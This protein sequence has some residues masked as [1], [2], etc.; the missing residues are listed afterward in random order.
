MKTVE[1]IKELARTRLEEAEILCNNGKYDGAFYL[2]GYSVELMLKAK[3]CQHLDI[4]DLF[5]EDAG[6]EISEK[7]KVKAAVKTVRDSV[8]SHDL[9][10]LFIYSGLA[11]KFQQAKA[12][13]WELMETYG[14]LISLVQAKE[15]KLWSE[16][17]R[18]LPIGTNNR[19]GVMLLIKL[20][21]DDGGLLKWIESN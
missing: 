20:L 5:D 4:D 10:V 7:V 12:N 13:Q 2:A 17:A 14:L 18:Y 15:Y 16:Q 9:S 21:K 11:K 3:I 8:K 6:I 19:I 1:Q